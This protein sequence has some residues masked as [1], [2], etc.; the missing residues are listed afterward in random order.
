M[1]R[2][3]ALIKCGGYRN[4]DYA[5]DA[6]LYWRLKN[7][8]QLYSFSE[9]LGDYRLHTDSI[10]SQSKSCAVYAAVWSVLAALSEQRRIKEKSDIDISHDLRTAAKNTKKLSDVETFILP[11]LEKDEREWFITAVCAKYLAICRTR[12]IETGSVKYPFSKIYS[13]GNNNET[14]V[15]Y[16]TFALSEIGLSRGIRYML[17]SRSLALS[18]RAAIRYVKKLFSRTKT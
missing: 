2:K 6:D 16:I 7:I 10:S 5:E 18:G 11:F 13:Y 15:A 14:I 1:L 8:G 4:F 9:I 17:D 3:S 12:K